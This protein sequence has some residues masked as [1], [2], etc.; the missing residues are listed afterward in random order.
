VKQLLIL[1]SPIWVPFVLVSSAILFVAWL[2][3]CF[4]DELTY[5]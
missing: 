5:K 1:T 3:F 2:A 4:L